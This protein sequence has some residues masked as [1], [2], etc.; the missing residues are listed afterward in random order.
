ME[1]DAQ[2]IAI[3]FKQVHFAKDRAITQHSLLYPLHP[4]QLYFVSS[5]YYSTGLYNLGV[6]QWPI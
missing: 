3:E 5:E 2:I 1:N 6:D 4:G